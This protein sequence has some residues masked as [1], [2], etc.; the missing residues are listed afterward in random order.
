[1]A[2]EDE[3]QSTILAPTLLSRRWVT[4]LSFLEIYPC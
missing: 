1:M 4:N 2:F 3:H